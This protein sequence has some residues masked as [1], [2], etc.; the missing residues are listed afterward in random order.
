MT[1]FAKSRDENGV[2]LTNREHLTTVA[3]LA[4]RFGVEIG[5]PVCAWISGLLHDFGK[6]SQ[7]FQNVLDGTASGIDHAVCAAAFLCAAVCPR[8]PSYRIVAEVTMAHHSLLQS[9]DA[10][11]PELTE[12][13]QGRGS[14]LCSTGKQAALF[15]QTEYATAWQGFLQDF[16]DFQFKALEKFSDGLQEETMLRTR[17]LFSCL[18]DAD[19]TASSGQALPPPAPLAPEAL[20]QRLYSQMEKLRSNSRADGALNRLRDQVFQ[21]C[22]DAGDSAPGLFTLTAPTGVGKTLALLHF[23]LRH[24]AKYGKRRIILVLPFLTLT[25]QSQRV[26][27]PLVPHILADHSQSRLSEEQRE[28]ATRWDAPFIITTS[29]RFFESLFCCHPGDCRKLHNI[30]DSVIL[31]DE[32]Q[33]LPADLAAATMKAAAALCRSYGCTMVFST[34]TQPDFAALPNLTGWN[35][36]EILPDIGQY[37]AALRRTQVDWRLKIP[38]P[39]SQI[40]A[41]MGRQGSVC[42]IVNLRRHARQLYEALCQ[43]CPPDERDSLFYL[44]TDLCPAHRMAVIETIQARLRA[45]Q[46]CRLVATQ[47][48]EAGVDLDFQA[49]YRA[50]APL[51]AIIQAAGRC[52]RNGN[53][54]G[55]GLVTVF[56]PEDSG[57]LYPGDSYQRG[58]EIVKLLWASG[59][60]DIHDPEIIA[61]YYRRL[62]S[63]TQEKPALT[64]AICSEDYAGVEQAYKLIQNHGVQVIVPYEGK[65]QLFQ[66]IAQRARAEGLTAG[67]LRDA[68]PIMVSCYNEELVCLHGEPVYPHRRSGDFPCG[69]DVYLL[70]TGHEGCYRAD[71][72]FSPEDLKPD[73]GLFLF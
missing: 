9:Y 42:A 70:A 6:Y 62:F 13:F 53:V 68:A 8:S 50:L 14:R 63:A 18:V 25:E 22:G 40:A 20:L 73:D 27:S 30:A 48:I 29:V 57:R 51:E 69:S 58:A 66:T 11:R 26:Y 31:F 10:I 45:H 61:A 65:A 23:A 15:G 35:P 72:G 39:L 4:Q 67:L 19:Y 64:T 54:P 56:L 43:S 12:L 5:M 38:T 59:N 34:A 3:E 55:G 28:L 2:Q 46:P 52:N 32:A 47:C 17:L 21:L 16:P 49:M 33:S 24:C 44:T 41:E 71:I 37:Y 1:Y 36:R 60:L 7:A